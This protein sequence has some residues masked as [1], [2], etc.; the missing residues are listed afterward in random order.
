MDAA[1]RHWFSYC[2]TST[3]IFHLDWLRHW[4]DVDMTHDVVGT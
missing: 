1:N 2:A 4:F 3:N